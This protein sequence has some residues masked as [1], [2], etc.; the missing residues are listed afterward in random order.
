MRSVIAALACMVLVMFMI[1]S[2]VPGPVDRASDVFAWFDGLGL[3]DFARY[4][5][6]QIATGETVREER[7][8]ARNSCYR[9]FL[10]KDDGPSLTVLT[11]T[12]ET[13]TY[14]KTA[15]GK[16]DSEKVGYE[17][18][19]LRKELTGLRTGIIGEE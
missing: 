3:A 6:V 1:G 10:V 19:D 4:K 17:P 15:P 16:P 7:Q 14:V 8:P 13:Q 5:F 2:L 11:R 18:W 9:A 12:L